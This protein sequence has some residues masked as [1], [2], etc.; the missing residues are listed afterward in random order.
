[1]FLWKQSG[2]LAKDIHHH[3]DDKKSYTIWQTTRLP[4]FLLGTHSVVCAHM[5]ILSR[6]PRGG[7]KVKDHG[8]A[9]V[10]GRNNSETHLASPSYIFSNGSR[11]PQVHALVHFPVTGSC[12]KPSSGNTW[13]R[14]SLFIV[15]WLP[16][17]DDQGNDW[18]NGWWMLGTCDQAVCYNCA[19]ICL[20]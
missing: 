17:N 6:S 16:G 12:L 4:W 3:R 10:P 1:M 19:M 9:N 2:R 15:V 11:R 20:G 14:P 13:Q 7:N 18:D 8:S 5:L